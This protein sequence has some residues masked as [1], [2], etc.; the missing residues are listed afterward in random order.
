[1]I[2]LRCRNEVHAVSPTHI[3]IE[4]NAFQAVAPLADLIAASAK[5]SPG[6]MWLEA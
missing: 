4:M 3:E 1:M 5:A 2:W 6:G